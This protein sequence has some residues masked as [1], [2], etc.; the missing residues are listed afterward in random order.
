MLFSLYAKVRQV[1][2]LLLLLLQLPK[3]VY[4]Y[5]WYFCFVVVKWLFKGTL[6]LHS[7]AYLPL[8]SCTSSASLSALFLAKI[9]NR[10]SVHVYWSSPLP[11]EFE[12]LFYAL[13]NVPWPALVDNWCLPSARH[14]F[15]TFLNP[16]SNEH[17]K[18]VEFLWRGFF[19]L[20][21]W[22]FF[23][24]GFI[25][26]SSIFFSHLWWSS[27]T[28]EVSSVVHHLPHLP[29]LAPLPL[30]PHWLVLELTFL[31][32]SRCGDF[33]LISKAMHRLKW[34]EDIP[35]KFEVLQMFA[36]KLKLLPCVSQ[37]KGY[38]SKS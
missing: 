34:L 3:S 16:G 7:V 31:Q 24:G 32:T 8:T 38:N 19:L 2:W 36:V 27:R 21:L 1:M 14:S 33:V 12:F 6:S 5:Y 10:F 35:D 29:I 13:K 25:N 4:Y 26:L 20:T 37:F 17:L 22:D 30:P 15:I 9:V 18:K 11:E 23:T 28:S